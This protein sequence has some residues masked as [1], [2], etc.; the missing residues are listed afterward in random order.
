VVKKPKINSSAGFIYVIESPLEDGTLK[1]GTTKN[2]GKRMAS[3][4][5]ALSKNLLV[6]FLYETK[7]AVQVEK[8][9]KVKLSPIHVRTNREIYELDLDSIKHWI[10][11]CANL[12]NAPLK[13]IL[14]KGENNN[15]VEVYNGIAKRIQSRNKQVK[16]SM[17]SI[18]EDISKNLK[19]GKKYYIVF[20]LNSKQ[21]I[22][23]IKEA[24]CEIISKNQTGGNVVNT[25]VHE[26]VSQHCD[27]LS[28]LKSYTEYRNRYLQ[29]KN[30]LFL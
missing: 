3:H 1:V 15:V 19:D 10:R 23:N 6:R 25:I 7:N 30:E 28:T 14:P 27:V 20:D 12:M 22:N 5:C 17:K 9:V 8:C 21:N 18:F 16:K 29:L 2:I 4:N 24:V 13:I 26:S 11:E